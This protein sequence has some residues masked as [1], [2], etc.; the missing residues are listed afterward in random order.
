[1]VEEDVSVL[2]DVLD[3]VA[4]QRVLRAG[5]LEK[6]TGSLG[7]LLALVSVLPDEP[8]PEP[9]LAPLEETDLA[10]LEV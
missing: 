4:E 5:L 2:K 1:M 9:D 8:E 6:S 7:W 3:E 10:R